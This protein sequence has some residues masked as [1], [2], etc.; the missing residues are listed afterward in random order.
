M[1]NLKGN[2]KM[3][4]LNKLRD[5]RLEKESKLIPNN[6]MHLHKQNDEEIGLGAT[7]IEDILRLNIQRSSTDEIYLK[8]L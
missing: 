5:L 1:K 8:K 4:L 6:S 3:K 2:L 7:T